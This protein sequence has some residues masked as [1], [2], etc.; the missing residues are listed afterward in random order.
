MPRHVHLPVHVPAD[1]TDVVATGP[2]PFVTT[3]TYV[4]PDGRR[5]QWSAR[6]DRRATHRGLTWRIGLLFG[7][8]SVCFVLGP[9]PAYGQAVGGQG[10]AVTFFVGS[11]FFTSG[12]LL[13]YAQVVR[14]AGHRWVGWE[15]RHAGF[16]ATLIQLAGTV[17]FN[18]STFAAMFD[19]PDNLVDRVVWRPDALGSICFLVASAIA[20][21]EAGHRWWSWRPGERDWHITALNMW[22]S[23]FFGF[24]AV[25][26]YVQPTGDLTN[27]Q[28]SNGGTLLGAACFLAA[29]LLTM[30]EGRQDR[31]TEAGQATR[32]TTGGSQAPGSA[33]GPGR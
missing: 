22:G 2:R 4:L 23:V 14:D 19:V 18:V 27:V 33:A 12:A 7:I 11:L 26:A 17:Y 8:G 32:R 13:S 16:W 9:I 3:V 30:G 10:V 5:R 20:F 31:S 6:Q 24:S 21:A 28:W 15:P 1:A 29:S 25:G